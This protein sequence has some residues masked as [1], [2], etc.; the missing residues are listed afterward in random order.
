MKP[1][2]SLPTE[3]SL[4]PRA[5]VAAALPSDRFDALVVVGPAPL[6]AAE[7]PAALRAAAAQA[8]R[9]DRPLGAG[10]AV[11]CVPAA[12]V[13]GERLVLSTTGPLTSWELDARAFGMAAAAGVARALEAGARRPLVWL[14]HAPGE[15]RFAHA[16]EVA[17]LGALGAL[18]RPLELRLR[19]GFQAPAD[20]LGWV[21]DDAA[22]WSS[23]VDLEGAR[24]AARDVTGTEPETMGP[25]AMG[26]YCAE[27][28]RGGPV[29]VSVEADQGRIAA[30]YPLLAAVGRASQPVE[31]HRPRLIRLV[32][33]GEGEAERTFFF[34]GK[35]LV[36]DTGGADLKT[37]GH[38]AGMSRDKGGAG[39]V[40]GLFAALAARRPRG[41]R[42][43]G[44]IG[45][46]RNSVGPH[47]YVTDEIV[48]ARS[49]TRVRIGNTDAEGRLVLADLLAALREEAAGRPAPHLFSIATLTGHAALAY[50]PYT[51]LLENGAARARGVGEALDR[52]G[53]AYGDPF[54]RSRLR[55]EDYAFIAG[56]APTED[57]ISCNTLP[58]ARTPR[59]HQFPAA[60]LD[61]VSGLRAH[62]A[63]G[64]APIA[65]AHLDIAGSVVAGG[66]WQT[67]TPTGAPVVAL[68]HGLSLA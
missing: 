63:K 54:E 26:E 46:V 33:E 44:L 21:D 65:F 60:F 41:V 14:S 56:R 66:T 58:S 68:M 49:G 29:A 62:N 50:G 4:V 38:M 53:E 16:R 40:V 17:A 27:L 12:G 3:L 24:T 8:E 55:P 11:G 22:A 10:R 23:A 57:V 25:A 35:G 51:A 20:A 19:E 32:Y 34:A 42:A 59:G 36:Y 6:S 45:A 9:V 37:D 52:A 64:G 67:G 2:P 28:F 13:P 30:G 39:A 31:A 15:P 47:G 7:A 43:V 48:T 1:A 5:D 61:V 18:W